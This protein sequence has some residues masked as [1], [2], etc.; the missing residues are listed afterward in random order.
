L[1]DRNFGIAASDGGSCPSRP[2]ARRSSRGWCNGSRSGSAAPELLP[3]SFRVTSVREVI[4]N[5]LSLLELLLPAMAGLAVWLVIALAL[6]IRLFRWKK[7][8]T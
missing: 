8:A 3:L 2:R 1:V 4:V 7:V 5:G 6:A